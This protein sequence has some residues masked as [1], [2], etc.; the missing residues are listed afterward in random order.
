MPN[1]HKHSNHRKD[2]PHQRSCNEESRPPLLPGLGP[3]DANAPDKS[4]AYQIADASHGSPPIASFRSRR[5]G[6]YAN[7]AKIG[8]VPEEEESTL[9]K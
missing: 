5:Q 8:L 4:L 3:G 7:L 2:R 9:T 6:Q 1:E